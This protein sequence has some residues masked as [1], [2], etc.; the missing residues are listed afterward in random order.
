MLNENLCQDCPRNCLVDRSKT[1]GFCGA[2]NKIVVAKVI[3]NFA[4]EEPSIS[5][6]KGTLAIF[7][8][9][10]NLKCE[11]CQNYQIS[12][13]AK[14]KEYSPNEFYLYL[15]GFDLSK[16]SAIEFITPTHFSS[17]LLEA[18][19]GKKLPLPI[20]WNSSGYEKKEMIETLAE[21]VDVFMP[22]LKYYSSELSKRYS[23]AEDYFDYASESIRAMRKLKPDIIIDGQMR[24]G[25]LV[26]HLVLPS[27]YKDSLKV[28]D[29][30]ASLG[31]TQISLMCQFTPTKYSSIK[32]RL[33]PLE[34]KIALNYAGKLGL[35][36]GY[37]QELSSSSED[38]IPDFN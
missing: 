14:G 32:R 10:C 21:I 37:I 24:Q 15:S 31:K 4:W 18:L 38:Y 25:L 5:G 29:Y 36:Q 6:E 19:R 22:D 2:H 3:E 12:R 33:Y 13:T 17:L 20:V 28:L 8:A 30:I 16:Y 11:F 26:R 35:N 9:G 23:L 34:Y 7:F 1:T 27:C